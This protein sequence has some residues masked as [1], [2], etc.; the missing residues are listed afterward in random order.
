M[1]AAADL[2]QGRTVDEVAVK[3]RQQRDAMLALQPALTDFRLYWEAI[4]NALT[5]RELI[6]I[7]SDKI[8]GRLNLMLFDPEQFRMPMFMPQRNGPKMTPKMMQGADG[9]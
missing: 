1:H 8:S 7:D 9:P 4:S 6:L 2:F 5:G 3:Y